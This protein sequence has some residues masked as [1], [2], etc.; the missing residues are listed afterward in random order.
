[1]YMYVCVYVNMHKY[2]FDVVC[3]DNLHI[4]QLTKWPNGEMN[5]VVTIAQCSH[6]TPT[7]MREI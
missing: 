3:V 4:G 2:N 7:K 5:P 1:M 6:M